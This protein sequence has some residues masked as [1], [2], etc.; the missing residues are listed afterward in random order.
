[1]TQVLKN[2]GKE[3]REQSSQKLKAAIVTIVVY[4]QKNLPLTS[5]LLISLQYLG[6]TR[7]KSK[8]SDLF[9][10]NLVQFFPHVILEEEKSLIKD[11]WKLLK[12][13]DIPE[14]WYLEENGN[15]KRL[16]VF[17]NKIFHIR[18]DSGAQKYTFLKKLIKSC[19]SLQ[20]G[21]AACERNLSDNKNTLLAE[22]TKL[23][24]EALLG[25][26]RA[27]EHSRSV[28]GAHNVRTMSKE[29]LEGVRKV[30]TK[31]DKRKAEIA[32]E[33]ALKAREAALAGQRRTEAEQRRKEQEEKV[34]KAEKR[35]SKLAMPMLLEKKCSTKL[36][37]G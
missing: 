32:A 19:L 18:S 36:L 6:P 17:W 15:P 7:I 25:L 20:N 34:K 8:S 23:S 5:K 4:F 3:R 35:R 10:S 9:I 26:R 37:S 14:E 1:M 30:K 24:D 28:N 12:L 2:A 16:D 22:R 13:E 31:H 33:K 11:E 29:M 21:N 27:K